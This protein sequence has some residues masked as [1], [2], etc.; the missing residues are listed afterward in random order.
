MNVLYLHSHDTGRFIS[1]YGYAVDTPA[2]AALSRRGIVFRRAFAVASSCSASR[3]ALQAGSY[4]HQNGMTGLAHRGWTL[5]DYRRHIVNVLREGGYRSTLIGQHHVA[6]DSA[7]I[8][9]DDVLLDGSSRWDD[10][11]S[12]AERW[13]AG[14]PAEPWFLSCGF[15]ET[16]RTSFQEIE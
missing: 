10:V 9:Y 14:A 5:F 3:A 7:M 15:W 11:A 12:V 6:P 16:H 13:L 8:G 2:F 4:P 1:P